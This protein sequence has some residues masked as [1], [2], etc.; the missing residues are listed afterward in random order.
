MCGQLLVRKSTESQVIWVIWFSQLG[1]CELLQSF[2]VLSF[3]W[4]LNPSP[5]AD[6]LIRMDCNFGIRMQSFMVSN[7]GFF[8]EG[9]KIWLSLWVWFMIWTCRSCWNSKVEV[10][11]SGSQHGFR[12]NNDSRHYHDES[13]LHSYKLHQFHQFQLHLYRNRRN[14]TL[15]GLFSF[16]FLSPLFHRLFLIRR[17]CMVNGSKS[18]QLGSYG[19]TALQDKVMWDLVDLIWNHSLQVEVIE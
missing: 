15:P 5:E 16:P 6:H 14:R 13:W 4:G 9:I 11:M 17:Y 3:K 10:D 7:Y 1:E 18:F 8:S 2:W 19:L 12:Q